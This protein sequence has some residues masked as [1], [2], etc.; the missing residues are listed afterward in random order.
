M[1]REVI[2]IEILTDEFVQKSIRAFNKSSPGDHSH[3]QTILEILSNLKDRYLYEISDLSCIINKG[4][5]T[6]SLP[7]NLI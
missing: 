4:K 6:P 5:N 1:L 3:N 2:P 7:E